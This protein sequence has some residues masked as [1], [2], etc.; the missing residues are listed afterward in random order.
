MGT[1]RLRHMYIDTDTNCLKERVCSYRIRCSVESFALW[2]C[3]RE[4]QLNNKDLF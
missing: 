3:R 2:G 4:M 1:L